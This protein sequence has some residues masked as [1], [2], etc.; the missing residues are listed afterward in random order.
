MQ[1]TPSLEFGILG[2]L[3]VW[4]EA[5]PLAIPGAKPR[6]LLALL[7]LH[8]NAP[9]SADRLIDALWGEQPPEKAKG[10][11]HV[12][13]GQLRRCLEPG[14]QRRSAGTVLVTMQAGYLLK[15]GEGALDSER[16]EALAAKGREHLA[17]GRID[18]AARRLRSALA[19][20]RGPAL[21]AFEY[22]PWARGEGERL[23]E[24]RLACLEDR[25]DADLRLG[26]HT[27]LVGELEALVGQHPL[28]ER[29]RGQLMLALYR[30]GRQAEALAVYREAR[31]ALVDELGIDPSSEL[32]E[33]EAAILRQDATLAASRTPEADTNL[34]S[35]PTPLIGRNRELEELRALLLRPEVRLVTVVGAGGIGKTRVA[36]ELAKRV[37]AH[38]PGGTFLCELAAISDPELMLYSIAHTL[39][40]E[41]RGPDHV[42]N[43][44]SRRSDDRE[45][46]LILD[47]FEHL[48]EAANDLAGLL[49][50]SPRLNVV[51]TS[52]VPLELRA[53]HR[54]PLVPLTDREAVE[55]FAQ[56]ATA[57]QPGFSSDDNVA[58][59]CRRLDYLPLAIELAA[60]RVDAVAA[61]Q[62]LVRLERRLPFLTGGL[63]DL[64]V[65]QRTLHATIAWSYDLLSRVERRAFVYLAVFVGGCTAQAAAE[66]SDADEETLQSLVRANLLRA[67]SGRFLMLD[68]VREFAAERLQNSSSG[69]KVLRRHA[70][71]VTATIERADALL[72]GPDQE[73][74]LD[75]IAIEHD[76]VRA[77]H[78]WALAARDVELALR[79]AAASG[80]FWFLRGYLEE[81]YRRVERALG[82]AGPTTTATYGN[83]LMRAGSLAEMRG[84]LVRA[85]TRYEEAFEVRR[86]LGD[87]SG[88]ANAVN[89]L[90]NVA[91]DQLD[92]AGARE[93]YERAIAIARLAD[94]S[95]A[96]VPGLFGVGH[97]LMLQG[98]P[99]D[100]RPLLEQSLALAER[101]GDTYQMAVH[102]E[103]LGATLLDLHDH[104]GAARLLSKSL[105]EHHALKEL[106]GVAATL[107]ELAAVAL[108]A[109][110][111]EQAATRLGVA[112]ALRRAVGA[113][114]L[115][116]EIQR[117]AT[118]EAA[119]RQALGEERF[120]ELFDAGSALD[121]DAAIE[122]ALSATGQ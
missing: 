104:E 99:A 20:W 106:I 50:A 16:F 6:A 80:W 84:D 55:L 32:R 58:E 52:R 88:A 39:G 5:V 82:L 3:E 78:D 46:L 96:Y 98:A 19:L 119:L 86:S 108:V 10:A 103:A 53:E 38:F 93:A 112:H 51:V 87:P 56:R 109:G 81:G 15:V 25:I 63:R 116:T 47:N 7:L 83:A 90:G 85:R 30:G 117:S 62:M 45:H 105:Q 97:V 68:T 120:I 41:P 65:R 71:W 61:D 70:E 59:I 95:S 11:L 4:E 89:S 107:E 111:A 9:L 67:E 24:L 94:P 27:E 66:V 14:R 76:N 29:M 44:L 49:A 110:E 115:A 8:R 26:H 113:Q 18:E 36:L 23:E 77:A 28:R 40:V 92:Y 57:V 42:I 37:S 43:E 34:P 12:Y 72:T 35:P 118:T 73:S 31:Q 74:V 1:A 60:A 79:I 101:Q 91:L 33:L 75:T 114:P 54:Y 21:A 17:A 13:I 102:H 122:S 100:A 69:D 2:P 121:Q 22:E 48:I 64:P